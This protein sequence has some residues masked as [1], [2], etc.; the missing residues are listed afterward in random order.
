MDDLSNYDF[1]SLT[2]NIVK[3]DKSFIN[4]SIDKCL[5]SKISIGYTR[6]MR[7]ILDAK[8]EKKDL[9]KVMTEKCQYW[10]PSK[11]EIPLDIFKRFEDC[12][13]GILGTWNT[14]LADLEL[15]DDAKPVCTKPYTVLRLH[16]AIFRK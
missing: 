14:A 15:N 12:F 13:Y 4:S 6:R 2:E 7:R 3:L 5:E 11:Q 1:K 9:N 8:Y 10:I 16:K